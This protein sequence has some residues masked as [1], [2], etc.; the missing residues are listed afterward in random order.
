MPRPITAEDLYSIKLA[1][2][3]RLSPD[4]TKLAYVLMQVDSESYQYRRSIWI[5]PVPGG[6]PRSFSSGYLDSQPRWSPDGTRLAFLR[7]PAA[8]IKATS[9]A[10]SERG[11]GKLQI[12]AISTSGG[13]AEQ[14]TFT[15]HGA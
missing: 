4:G 15:R 14:L 12:D 1:E 13:E 7:A 3:P 2:D 9:T 8:E 6:P 5:S 11:I 10:E